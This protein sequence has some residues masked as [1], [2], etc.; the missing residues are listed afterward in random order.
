MPPVVPTPAPTPAAH[1]GNQLYIK[2]HV[3]QRLGHAKES[4]DRELKNVLQLITTYVEERI[5]VADYD[6]TVMP[7]DTASEA[8]KLIL[9]FP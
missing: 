8:M 4:C 5:Q 2:R 7:L 3:W 9:T 1:A 6:D